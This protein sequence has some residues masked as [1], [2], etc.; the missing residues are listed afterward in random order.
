MYNHSLNFIFCS[1]QLSKL[2]QGFHQFTPPPGHCSGNLQRPKK[3]SNFGSAYE[4]IGSD[5]RSDVPS[6]EESSTARPTWQ[7]NQVPRS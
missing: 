4:S 7:L 1:Y 3:S 6:F 5:W 2:T